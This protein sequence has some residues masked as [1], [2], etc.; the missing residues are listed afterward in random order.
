[1]T[2]NKTRRSRKNLRKT[3]SSRKKKRSSSRRMRKGGNPDKFPFKLT[4]DEL[5]EGMRIEPVPTALALISGAKTEKDL[6]EIVTFLLSFEDTLPKVISS[7]CLRFAD[8]K[9]RNN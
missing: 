6:I 2:Y 3:K 8:I 4:H 1:M 9:R 7:V 5:D